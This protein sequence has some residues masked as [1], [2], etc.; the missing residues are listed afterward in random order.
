MRC[1]VSA[2]LAMLSLA[3]AAAP[4]KIEGPATITAQNAELEG[5]VAVYTG[6]VQMTSKTFDLKGDRLELSRPSGQQAY[7]ITL[8]GGPATLNHES[9]GS[10]DPSLGARAK[11]IIY[12]SASQDIDLSGGVELTRSKD[13]LTGESVHYNVATRSVKAQGGKS[14]IKI[15]LDLPSAQAQLKPKSGEAPPKP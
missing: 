4:L 9:T 2:L 3:A 11:T 14:Q 15:V 6:N 1:L 12:H 5:D 7:M 8:T 10:D 13:V